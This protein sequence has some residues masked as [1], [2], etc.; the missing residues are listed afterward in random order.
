MRRIDWTRWAPAG[1]NGRREAGWLLA[2][3][4]LSAAVGAAA[5]LRRLCRAIRYAAEYGLAGETIPGFPEVLGRSLMGF[6]LVLIAAAG[7][8]V[9]HVDLHYRG[10]RSIY[11]MRRL[12]D[13]WG[14]LRRCGAI[15]LAGAGAGLLLWGLL[16]LLFL[17][18]YVWLTPAERLGADYTGG[19]WAVL[20]R[21]GWLC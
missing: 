21:G 13:R 12:P 10:S 15:P 17:A 19:L 6:P 7:L 18:L 11:L 5:F 16:K 8:A 1:V 14:L 9:Y 20:W 2:G 3:L 4:G